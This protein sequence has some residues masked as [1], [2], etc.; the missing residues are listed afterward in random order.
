MWQVNDEICAKLAEEIRLI[1]AAKADMKVDMDSTCS[2]IKAMHR[3]V[4]ASNR[5]GAI[6]Y[7]QKI[8]KETEVLKVSRFSKDMTAHQISISS[9]KNES[10]E[11]E[12]TERR[13][14]LCDRPKIKELKEWF[15]AYGKPIRDSKTNKYREFSRLSK[16]QT[17]IP[18]ASSL[19]GSIH[20][21]FSKSNSAKLVKGTLAN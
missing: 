16:P 6:S 5:A 1:D 13:R 21:Q 4:S 14:W 15:L 11:L 7:K 18:G 9:L 12:A 2:N 19:D 17:H 3:A 20:F 10:T 8:P